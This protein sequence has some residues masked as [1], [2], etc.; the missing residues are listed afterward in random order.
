[1]RIHH[2]LLGIISGAVGCEMGIFIYNYN[3]MGAL[4]VF[5]MVN[6]LSVFYLL[7]LTLYKKGK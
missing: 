2:I 3:N 1:M 4:E 6:S 5:T 7:A